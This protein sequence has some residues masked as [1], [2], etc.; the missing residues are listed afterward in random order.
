MP[1]RVSALMEAGAALAGRVAAVGAASRRQ[2]TVPLASHQ[3]AHLQKVRGRLLLRQPH[4]WALELPAM[5]S[6]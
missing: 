5:G 3:L 2:T 1:P 4:P 6:Q